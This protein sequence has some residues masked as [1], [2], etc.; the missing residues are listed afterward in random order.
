[1]SNLRLCEHPAQ[2]RLPYAEV[3]IGK[4]TEPCSAR[5]W[6]RSLQSRVHCRRSK[7]VATWTLASARVRATKLVGRCSA[8]AMRTR[9]QVGRIRNRAYRSSALVVYPPYITTLAVPPTIS[10]SLSGLEATTRAEFARHGVMVLVK[11]EVK[12]IIHSPK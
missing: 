4:K 10:N 6:V 8:F 5:W 12:V 2:H 9:M 11:V 3:S 1:M 7:A